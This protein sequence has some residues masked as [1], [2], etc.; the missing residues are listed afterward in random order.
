MK[1]KWLFILVI[2]TYSCTPQNVSLYE[3]DP[4]SLD[5]NK[6]TLT[7]IA[8]DIYYI[9]LDNSYPLG[10]IYDN[11]EFINKTIYISAKDIGVLV[12]NKN[13]QAL[14]KIGS[15]GRGPGEYVYNY[16]FTVDEN[17]EIVY[18]WDSG[19]IIKVYSKNGQFLRS[20]SLNE[21]GDI[22]VIKSYDSKLYVFF[23]IQFE[24]SKYK[25]IVVDSNG[26]LIKK[27]KRKTPPFVSNIGG[28]GG[29]YEF[30]N[31]I[32]YWNNF[33]T[34]TVFSISQDLTE[35]LLFLIRPGEHRFPK[36]KIYSPIDEMSKYMSIK[37]IFE[38]NRFLAI[39]YFYKKPAFVL[40]DK[41][42]RE[43]FLTYLENDKSHPGSG[44]TG[45]IENDLD[46]GVKLLPKG[47]FHENESEYMFGLINPYQVKFLESN[48][49]FLNSTP[50]YS[51]KKKELEKLA[52]NLK[53][54]DNPILM[55]VRLKK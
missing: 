17:A 52:A 6:I 27:E 1:S 40:I 43:S 38:T 2:L 53:E 22:D 49:K 26:R 36:E 30:E 18:L 50:K 41:K 51:E 16:L 5:E 11:I 10:V 32:S 34:D 19:N 55:I 33:F 13:G 25:W 35:K 24:N 7:E 4:R 15:I 12:Y 9:P 48:V 28:L 14:K 46:G 39:N 29:T 37:Q 44:L 20:F 31:N 42:T 47:Y 8:D 54:T 21:F 3:F 23:Q 45:G